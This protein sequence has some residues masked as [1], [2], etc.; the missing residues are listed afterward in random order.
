MS[1]R[2]CVWGSSIGH[3][4][5]DDV[6]G[7]WCDRL[8][9][10]YFADKSSD[11]SVYNLSISGA[12]SKDVLDRFDNEYNAR[13][14]KIVLI[15]IGINDSA[16][17]ENVNGC[18]ISLKNTKSNLEQLIIKTRE[19]GSRI[20]FVGLTSVNEDLVTPIPWASNVSYSNGNIK[21]YDNI[22]KEVAEI[23]N[24]PY[25]YMFDLLQKDD[26]DDGLHPNTKGHEKMFERIKDF[27]IENNIV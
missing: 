23:N 1:K 10:Y 19:R 14:P 27:L 21:K 18:R 11:I 25:C 5:N 22:I 4:Y 12:M 20:M 13:Q 26:L 24:V 6:G 17:D 15:A 9:V 7:G 3:G 16:F 2:I 8:K